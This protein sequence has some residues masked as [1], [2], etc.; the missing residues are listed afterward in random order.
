MAVVG[1]QR[2][3]RDVRAMSAYLPTREV[4]L[5]CRER[6]KRA[7]SAHRQERRFPRSEILAHGSVLCRVAY[8]KRRFRFP[9]IAY[10]NRMEMRQSSIVM[11]R[12]ATVVSK[13]M[14]RYILICG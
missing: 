13:L 12:Q 1:H 8:L 14:D 10:G 5:R 2:R 6:S 11:M 4:I 7:R 9:T 3:F